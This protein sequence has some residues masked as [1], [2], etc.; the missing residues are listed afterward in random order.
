ME[1]EELDII[2]K[3]VEGLEE[4]MN[5]S[6]RDVIEQYGPNVATNVLVNLGTTMIAKA[7]ILV[8]PEARPHIEYV[9]YKAIDAK[10]EE[11]HAAI[12]SLMAIGKAMGGGSTCQPW[13]PRKH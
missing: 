8:H 1:D 12:E 6:M 2:K 4:R 5:H 10:V 9:A 7:L 11:G 13:P 3:I